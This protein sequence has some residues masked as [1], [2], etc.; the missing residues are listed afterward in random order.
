MSELKDQGSKMEKKSKQKKHSYEKWTTLIKRSNFKDVY[1]YVVNLVNNNT[2]FRINDNEVIT[3]IPLCR[4]LENIDN[5]KLNTTDDAIK[6][7][8]K[9]IYPEYESELNLV[10]DGGAEKIKN[11]YNRVKNMIYNLDEQEGQGL[12]ILSPEQMITRFPI[13]LAQLKAV[14]NS[15][16][17]KNEIRQ[18]LHSLYRSKKHD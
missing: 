15:E 12:K 4:F 18:I 17:R 2:V 7:F 3:I 11:A 5:D 16:K 8:S 9:R 14:N 1:N 10:K 13:L 6:Y